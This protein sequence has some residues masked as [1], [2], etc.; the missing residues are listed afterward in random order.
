MI[1]LRVTVPIAC[2]R[3]GFA[4][5]F[6]ETEELPPPATCYGFL[7]SLVGEQDRRRHVGVRV[8]PALLGRPE[9][10]AVLRTLWRVKKLPLGSPGNTRPDYQEILTNVCLAIWLDSTEEIGTGPTLEDRVHTA[11]D[12]PERINRFGGLSLGESTHLVDEVTR[13]SVAPGDR[14]RAYLLN[15]RGRLSLPVWVDHVG[16]AKTRYVSGDLVETDVSAPNRDRM[17]RIEPLS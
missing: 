16:S 11:L 8:C 7:L 4:R 17:P 10:S 3:K 9:R 13:L 12:H 6:W 2:F 5:E 15:D 14:A 1:A